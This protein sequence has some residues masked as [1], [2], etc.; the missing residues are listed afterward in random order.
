MHSS[1]KA[2]GL[3]LDLNHS[4]NSTSYVASDDHHTSASVSLSIK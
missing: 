4:S 1:G 2:T 3:G